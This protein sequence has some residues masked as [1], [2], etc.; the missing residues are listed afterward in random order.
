MKEKLVLLVGI[1]L[2]LSATLVGSSV[3]GNRPPRF[4]IDEQTE[5]V[6]R[7]KEGPETPVG[8]PNDYPNR[9]IHN[10]S[11]KTEHTYELDISNSF[12]NFTSFNNIP[13]RYLIRTEANLDSSFLI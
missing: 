9:S 11:A 5:I 4:I 3:S 12:L 1:Y 6:I 13:I 7:L 2:L 8:K 10:M